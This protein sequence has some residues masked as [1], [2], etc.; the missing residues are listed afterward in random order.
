[1][2]CGHW[3][4]VHHLSFLWPQTWDCWDV[5]ILE[6]V[7]PVLCLEDIGKS[8]KSAVEKI[9][10]WNPFSFTLLSQGWTPILCKIK[11][12]LSLHCEVFYYLLGRSKIWMLIK[13]LSTFLLHFPLPDSH[14]RDLCS[15]LSPGYSFRTFIFKSSLLF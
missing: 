12:T 10:I 3:L 11:V 8:L 2:T 14:W 1:M 6:L 15:S 13:F 5:A 9:H 7:G 4:K